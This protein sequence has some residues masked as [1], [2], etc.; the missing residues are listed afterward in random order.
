MTLPANVGVR[1]KRGKVNHIEAASVGGRVVSDAGDGSGSIRTVTP[2]LPAIG[3]QF[4]LRRHHVGA[5]RLLRSRAKLPPRK[6]I[7]W[8]RSDMAGKTVTKTGS[9]YPARLLSDT[10]SCH[11]D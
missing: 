3:S 6:A 7:A 8:A 2:F 9:D 10:F 1:G 5:A 4:P 11:S